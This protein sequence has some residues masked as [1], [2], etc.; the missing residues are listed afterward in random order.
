VSFSFP[1]AADFHDLNRPDRDAQTHGLIA[2][3]VFVAILL[4]GFLYAWKKKAL[5]WK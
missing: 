4:I 1:W 5:E 2:V 3:I